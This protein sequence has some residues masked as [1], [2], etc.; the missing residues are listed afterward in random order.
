MEY[1]LRTHCFDDNCNLIEINFLLQNA[2]KQKQVKHYIV[3]NTRLLWLVNA[4]IELT[5][6]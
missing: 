3:E 4:A 1:T 2:K 6:V 5:A